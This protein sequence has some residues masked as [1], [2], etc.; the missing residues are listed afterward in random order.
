MSTASKP[1][2]P[3]PETAKPANPD[4]VTSKHVES[5]QPDHEHVG[6]ISTQTTIF[7]L[8][9]IALILY[10]IQ[11]IL[12][13]FVLAGV[14]AYVSTPAIEWSGARS[15]LPR[16]FVALAIFAMFLTLG[17]VIGYFGI[18]PF[19]RA[20]THVFNDF[21]S[22]IRAFAQRMIGDGKISL[23]GQPMNAEELA[24]AAGNGLRDWFSQT[25]IVAGLSGA[26]F[27][28]ML[29]LVL[30]LVLLCYFLLSGRASLGDC[31]GWC[32]HN[33]AR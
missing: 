5:R 27:G 26:L 29:G 25:R 33:S 20:M 18:P 13:P 28:T 30:T 21:E 7:V 16:W 17:S 32:R 6:K 3:K 14:L 11:W 31:C 22:I 4:P 15:G 19:V 9:A 24:Q 12:P 2:M 1:V 10:E 23:L 8:I